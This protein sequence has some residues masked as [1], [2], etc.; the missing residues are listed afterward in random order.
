MGL[1]S[2]MKQVLNGLL[3]VGMRV[4]DASIKLMAQAGLYNFT[5]GVESIS[6]SG[7][8]PSMDNIGDPFNFRGIFRIGRKAVDLKG[9]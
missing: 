2:E 6:T 4:K 5:S 9:F 7:C 1:T 8:L 3:K